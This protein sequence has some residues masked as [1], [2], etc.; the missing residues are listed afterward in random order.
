MKCD[1]EYIYWRLTPIIASSSFLLYSQAGFA[2]SNIVPDNSLGNENSVVES[3]IEGVLVESIA[4]GAQR[5]QNLFHSFSEF[6]IDAGRSAY[7]NIPDADINNIISRV[8]GNNPSNIM[9]TLGTVGGSANLFLINPNG[10]IFGENASL[11]VGG[12]FVATTADRIQFGDRGFFDTVDPEAPPLLTV[13]PSAFL[14]D[15]INPGSIQNNSIATAGTDPTQ[16][17]EFFGLRVPDGESSILLGGDVAINSGGIVALDG[18]INIGAVKAGKVELDA[19]NNLSFANNSIRGNISLIDGAGLLSSG[20]DGGKIAIAGKNIN[21][22]GNSTITTGILS[23]LGFTQAQAG[24]LQLNATGAIAIDNSFVFNR[25]SENALGNSGNLLIN[26]TNLSITN[27]GQAGVLT[28]GTGDTGNID[29]N[30]DELIQ[31]D[32]GSSGSLT[33]IFA[34]TLTSGRGNVGTTNITAKNLNISNATIATNTFGRGNAGDIVIDAGSLTLTNAGSLTTSTF[35]EGDAGKVS[36]QIADSLSLDGGINN[37]VTGIFTNVGS[38]AIGRGG[39]ITVAAQNLSLTDGAQLQSLVNNS[40][41]DLAGGIGNAGS[42][43]IDVV[44]R[45][46]IIGTGNGFSSAIFSEV[47]QGAIGNAGNINLSGEFLTVAEGGFLTSSSEGRGNVGNIDLDIE[48]QVVISDAGTR[49][50]AGIDFSAV[51]DT[52]GGNLTINTRQ[53]IVEDGAQVSTSTFGSGDAGNFTVNATE[54]IQ[55]RG[56]DKTNSLPGGLFA[57]VNLTGEGTGGNLTINTPQLSISDGSKV[58]VATFGK[59]DAG[60]L[61]INAGKIDIFNTPTLSN[62]TTGIFGSVALDP[63]TEE[64][65]TGNGGDITILTEQLSIL[66]GGKISV[67]TEGIGNAGTLNITATES[68]K[69]RGVDPEPDDGVSFISG[70]VG[71]N[72]TGRGGDIKIATQNLS[73]SDLAEVSVSSEGNG[74]GGNLAINANNLTLDDSASIIAETL[75]TDGGNINLSVSDLLILDRQSKISTTAGTAEA[76]GNGGNINLDTEFIVAFPNG[77]NDITAN[78]FNGAG[79]NIDITAESIFGLAARNSIPVNITNDIDASSQFGLDGNISITT[80]DI[81]PTRGIDTLPVDI[82][83]ASQLI[84]RTCLGGGN[85]QQT[86]KFVVTGRGGLPNNPNES[87]AGDASLSA[88][89][90]SLPE[91]NLESDKQDAIDNQSSLDNAANAIVEAKGWKINSQG[92]VI[93]T[94]AANDS[95]LNVPWLDSYSCY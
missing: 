53:L 62:F 73:I 54:S 15:R 2:Q 20:Q 42:V 95:Q 16:S 37:L 43:N 87:L 13:K 86:N 28:F 83:D 10:I 46:D 68:I 18:A 74:R 76:G 55:L 17:L 41:L 92:K 35:G 52:V 58:Q 90:V 12:S 4:G 40:T 56:E 22:L 72:A 67:V 21:V 65:P 89:W 64:L 51:G 78:A 50:D 84:T 11:D 5:G 77:N 59:G 44:D 49:V 85:A 45:I 38:G 69:I 88:D 14:F 26:A 31:L 39:E 82:V 30:V 91:D 66:D 8:T 9:G 71:E 32:S 63:R 3:N 7:F 24:D 75:T 80:P 25:V 48:Q 70:N 6:N 93:L 57:Q 36:L 81:D 61:N 1:R 94:A 19:D 23:N 79:G 60:E 29:I 27:G 47:G 34:R 33:G